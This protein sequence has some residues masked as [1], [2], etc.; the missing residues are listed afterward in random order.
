MIE[1]VF[2]KGNIFDSNCE[3]L[4]NPV[5]TQG[6]AGKGLALEFKHRFPHN[7]AIYKAH[8]TSV[9]KMQIGSLTSCMDCGRVIINFPTKKQWRYNSSLEYIYQGLLALPGA[10]KNWK[11]RSI[12]IPALGCGEGRLP[13]IDVKDLIVSEVKN[14]EFEDLLIEVYEPTK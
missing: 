9:K 4:V 10:I 7:H 13:W 6:V 12:A 14:W 8:C 5:N 3:A 1:L 11:L 2:K